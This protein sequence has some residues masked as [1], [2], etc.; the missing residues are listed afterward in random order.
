MQKWNWNKFLGCGLVLFSL[1][2][3]AEPKAFRLS[4]FHEP[5]SI[6]PQLSATSG[7][8]YLMQSL[9]RNLFW[10]DNQRGLIPDLAEKC[11][12]K[13]NTLKCWIKSDRNWSDGTPI[14]AED[15]VRSY[16]N[17]VDPAVNAPRAFWLFPVK[18]A[19]KIKL[20]KLKPADLGV[21]ALDKKIL[22][23]E[24]ETGGAEFESSLVPG[25]L[26]P[27]PV[28]D[29]KGSWEVIPSSG[30]YKISKFIKGEKFVLSPTLNKSQPAV[31]FYFIA[32]ESMAFQMYQNKKLDF[33][34][35][36]PT[37]FAPKYENTPEFFMYEAFRFD[38]YGMSLQIPDKERKAL[39]HGL[40][41][42]DLQKFLFSK[43]KHGCVGVPISWYSADPE[44]EMCYDF[45]VGKQR[46]FH[47]PKDMTL[48]FSSLGGEDHRRVSEWIQMEWKKNLDLDI[49]I[50]SLENPILIEKLRN[51]KWWLFRKGI[52]VG[53]PT[54]LAVL[55]IFASDKHPDN[56]WKKVVPGIP[57][58]AKS[59]KSSWTESQKQKKCQSGLRMIMDEYRLI[60][61]GRYSLT[62]LAST[63]F[64]G[65]KI[66]SLN[67]LDL[68]GLT[69]K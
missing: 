37:S 69:A 36:I 20:G 17:L 51:E 66:N 53:R 22:Q 25:V 5:T 30:P 52:S 45:Q 46:K 4:L 21:K 31:E 63:G 64:T 61:T 28:A 13:K 40:N 50:R 60:P 32:D 26:S 3:Q 19:E 8:S 65:W 2:A 48:L 35:R 57:E 23:F 6:N 9:F 58:L 10:Y 68:G 54:C 15:F 42:T 16:R 24:F 7:D 59:W 1:T 44:K 49:Q 41:Y 34:R 55:E 62:G 29:F 33:L 38:F 12:R 67:Q 56:Y 47:F 14:T 11:E 39:A 43:G 27:V 18:N